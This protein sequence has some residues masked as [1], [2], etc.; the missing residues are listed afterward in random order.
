MPSDM[1][2]C[3]GALVSVWAAVCSG[4]MAEI[5]GNRKVGASMALGG[6]LTGLVRPLSRNPIQ[7]C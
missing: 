3:S 5:V 2:V 4:V 6:L 7:S 1:A